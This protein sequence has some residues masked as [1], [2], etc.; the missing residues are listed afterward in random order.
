MWFRADIVGRNFTLVT[1][2]FKG[3]EER[4]KWIYLEIAYGNRV[5]WSS[6]LDYSFNTKRKEKSMKTKLENE[7]WDVRI[8]NQA[9]LF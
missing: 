3:W 8:Q 7:D 9:S 2:R 1:L 5:T 6:L 4:V